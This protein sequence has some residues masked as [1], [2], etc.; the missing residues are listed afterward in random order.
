MG[1]RRQGARGADVQ[2]SQHPCSLTQNAY[3]TGGEGPRGWAGPERSCLKEKSECIREKNTKCR[4]GNASS[5]QSSL[6]TFCLKIKG[7]KK[8]EREMEE[9]AIE[10]KGF[11][12]PQSQVQV[13]PSDLLTR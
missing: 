12:A 11:G 8:K 10:G 6:R 5:D 9:L 2:R 13:L 4:G 3:V 1:H 7:K